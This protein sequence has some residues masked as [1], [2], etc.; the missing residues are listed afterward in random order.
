MDFNQRKLSK[1]S[2]SR[3]RVCPIDTVKPFAMMMAPAYV[4]M[5]L[6]EKFVM[7]KKP[8]DFFTP[9]EL[10]HFQS[11]E[12]LFFPQ[13]VDDA[14]R[15]R[16][17]AR[18]I[19]ELLEWK[20]TSASGD[21]APASYELSDAVIRMIA[22]L[23]S[24][25]PKVDPFFVAVFVNELCSL[26]PEDSL[27]EYHDQNVILYEKAVFCS[28]WAVFLAL[29]LGYC[30]LAFLNRLRLNLIREICKEQKVPFATAELN[31]L[32]RLAKE[33]FPRQPRALPGN[34]IEAERL[35]ENQG[36]TSRKLSGRFRR[37]ERLTDV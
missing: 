31:E 16:D 11:F 9:E 26:L 35:L 5:R 32:A 24:P 34:A 18:Q 37:L 25:G 14:L 3:M 6:N 27:R 28:S 15:F 19:R 33:C 30:E 22:P 1:D 7:V 21:I 4:Y 23:W 20:P 8:F 13:E 36:R 2:A 17:A 10:T 29:H 12:S